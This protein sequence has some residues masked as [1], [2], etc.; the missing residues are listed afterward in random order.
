MLYQDI[1]KSM[2]DPRHLRI[3]APSALVCF[4]LFLLLFHFSSSA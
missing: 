1:F 4:S 2:F 3:L